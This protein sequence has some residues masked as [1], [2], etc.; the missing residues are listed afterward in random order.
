MGNLTEDY[1]KSL[2]LTPSS[3]SVTSQPSVFNATKPQ[4]INEKPSS[5]MGVAGIMNASINVATGIMDMIS[6]YENN[7]L[8][9]KTYKFNKDM[10]IKNYN[11]TKEAYNRRVERGQR[12][13]DWTSGRGSS[14]EE[15]DALSRERN[16]GMSFEETTISYRERQEQFAKDNAEKNASSTKDLTPINPPATQARSARYQPPKKK[17]N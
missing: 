12:L 15:L 4:Q 8:A 1:L 11:L 3:T 7:R 9:K 13:S 2:Q 17:G 5:G 14:A 10:A 6:A 16:N